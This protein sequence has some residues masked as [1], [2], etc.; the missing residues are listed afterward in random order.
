MRF[1]DFHQ[2]AFYLL[3]LAGAAVPLGLH[4]ARVF[5]GERTF[6]DSVM[7]PL[8]GMFYRF[9][10]IEAGAEMRWTQYSHAL[11]AFNLAGAAFLYLLMRLQALLPL[12]HPGLSGAAPDLT[13]NTAVSF[14]TNT[15][16][17]AYGGETTLSHFVQM[18]GMTV[19]NFLSA[20]T[21]IA[22]AMALMRGFKRNECSTIGNFWFDVTRALTFVLLP[23]SI[24]FAIFLVS[25]GVPQNLSP[26]AEIST[27]E[28]GRQLIAQGPVASQEAIKIIGT[29][30]GGFFNV[31]SA[32]PYENPNALSNFFHLFFIFLIP[33]AL[34]VTFGRMMKDWRHGLVLLVAMLILF[35]AGYALTCHFENSGNTMINQAMGGR[36]LPN[37]EGKEVRFGITA[38]SLYGVITTAA[39][40]G[41]V[42][43]MHDS[44]TPLGGM[45]LLLNIVIGEVIFGGVGAGFYG[46]ILF[47]ILTVFIAGLMVGRTPEYLG[48]KIGAFEI[49]MVMIAVLTAP[50]VILVFTAI[51]VLIPAG[52]AGITNPG[53]HGLTQVLYAFSSPANNNGS[54]FAGIQCNSHFYNVLTGL[55]ML[56]GR[57]LVIIPVLAIAGSMA[58]KRSIPLSRGTFPTTGPLF[59]ALLVFVILMV[60]AL[61]FFPVLSL[62]PVIEHLQMQG[63]TWH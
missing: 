33:A 5:K 62:G 18:L 14:M 53:P 48:K 56:M 8:E 50:A 63:G 10:H 43:S 6:L 30:G 51:S 3:V 49:K 52:K 35:I 21:G 57:F 12:N 26:H 2:L 25:Q 46:I 32:H 13:F 58:M 9:I 41:A 34:C 37:M 16:W 44:Y 42:N 7:K 15:N 22:V 47:A 45:I 28:G 20:A 24:I 38:S 39:S 55:A 31:N 54:A 17:Q 4:M 60:G 27:L 61:T 1:T 36:S 29:N 19:Q 59:A 23:L 11:L 40:C